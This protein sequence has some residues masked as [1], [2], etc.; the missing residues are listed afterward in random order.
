MYFYNF[1]ED[2]AVSL[3]QKIQSLQ[4]MVQSIQNLIGNLASAGESIKK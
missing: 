1:K 2:K 3:R 4:E